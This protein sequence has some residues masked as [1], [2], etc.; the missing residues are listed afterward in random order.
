MLNLMCNVSQWKQQWTRDMNCRVFSIA[1]DILFFEISQAVHNL[2]QN[3]I[4]WA[5][6]DYLIS[7]LPICV[8]RNH[9]PRILFTVIYMYVCRWHSFSHVTRQS[10][11]QETEK[12]NWSFACDLSFMLWTKWF[13]ISSISSRAPSFQ[14][15]SSRSKN[16]WEKK[17]Q[18]NADVYIQKSHSAM[19]RKKSDAFGIAIKMGLRAISDRFCLCVQK[20]KANDTKWVRVPTNNF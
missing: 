19:S 8:L 4:K 3:R 17:R 10:I 9:L 13:F 1:R 12:K 14:L 7:D 6:C 18:L 16:V 5:A 2:N 15:Y 11:G 20:R